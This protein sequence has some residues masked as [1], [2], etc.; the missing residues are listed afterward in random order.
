MRK[1]NEGNIGERMNGIPTL[2]FIFFDGFLYL[3]KDG[4]KSKKKKAV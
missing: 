2:N 4:L 3:R 1:G